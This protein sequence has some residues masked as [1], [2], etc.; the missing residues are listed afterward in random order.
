MWSRGE[1][2]AISSRKTLE[3]HWKGK[4]EAH[5]KTFSHHCR[6]KTET[7]C[8]SCCIK[9]HYRRKSKASTQ[10]KSTKDFKR[11]VAA[12]SVNDSYGSESGAYSWIRD[13]R[14]WKWKI[15]TFEEV[16]R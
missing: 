15:Q 4:W 16:I 11:K 9:M 13:K 2:K 6:D 3:E 14:T 7:K 5:S 12:S 8:F 10:A 1:A